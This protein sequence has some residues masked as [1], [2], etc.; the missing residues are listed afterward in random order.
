MKKIAAIL[1]SVVLF[2]CMTPAVVQAQFTFILTNGSLTVTAYTG[3]GGAVTIPAFAANH[4]VTAIGE[5]AFAD[6]TNLTSIT[7]PNS[8][9]NI[10]AEAFIQCSSL[11]NVIIGNGVASIGYGAFVQCPAL[12]GVSIGS[13]V[14][15]MGSYAFQGCPSL[16]LIFFQGNA[17]ASDSTAFSGERTNATVY[18]LAGTT[19][20]STNFFGLSAVLANPQV[21]SLFVPV[22][23]N[24]VFKA[25]GVTNPPASYQWYFI[26]PALQSPAGAVAE[27]LDGFVYGAVLTNQGS[28]YTVIPSVQIV[29][30]GGS[31]AAGFAAI[32]NGMVSA[33]TM[34][35]AGLDYASLPAVVIDPPNGLLVGQ[36]N[37]TLTL[38]NVTANNVGNYFVVATT[39]FF[40]SLTSSVA[41]LTLASPPTLTLQ[42][43]SQTATFGADVNFTA[44]ATGS[45]PLAWQWWMTGGQQSNATAV[46]VVSN[47]F[48]L[49]ASLTSEGAGYLTVPTVQLLGGSGHGAGAVATGSNRMVTAITITNA[50]FGY[51][52]PPTL[53]IGASVAVRL[54][55]QTNAVL[56]LP[57]VGSPNAGNYFVV[58]TNAFG[59]VT[60]SVAMLTVALPANN[61]ITG[62]QLIGNQMVLSFVGTPQANYALDRTFNLSPADWIPQF[63]NS[64]D[65]F[66]ILLLTNAPDPTTN[67]FWRLRLVP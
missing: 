45:S 36:T 34:T 11:T 23:S 64:A 52:N 30:G 42:P 15:T 37:A 35:N 38:T 20:W 21:K 55:G 12:V 46:L 29:G 9:T 58:L 48:V 22:A 63:T 65:A 66:G 14:T 53:Q 59:S 57:T 18:Y 51:T 67:N 61:Q 32:S 43:A 54:S 7:I 47:G 41:T 6:C 16:N 13:G 39:A 19:G 5:T 3:T 28:G 49:E 33:I 31:G 56:T 17:P 44:A 25:V 24:A 50:G 2:F 40:G 4:P 27:V 60:S 10:G 26:N 8:V 1:C 62:E